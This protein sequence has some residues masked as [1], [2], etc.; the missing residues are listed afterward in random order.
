MWGDTELPLPL[1][2]SPSGATYDYYCHYLFYFFLLMQTQN[3]TQ[4]HY[5]SIVFAIAGDAWSYYYTIEY[6]TV[7]TNGELLKQPSKTTPARIK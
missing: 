3:N 5:K 7:I 2:S 1:R 6:L 4:W